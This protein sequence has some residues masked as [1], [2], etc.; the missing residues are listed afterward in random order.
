M[1]EGGR[2]VR[3]VVNREIRRATRGRQRGVELGDADRIGVV[4]AGGDMRQAA[5]EI[6]GI[7][8]APGLC[9]PGGVAKRDNMVLTCYRTAAHGNQN[10]RPS[11]RKSVC[12]NTKYST[13]A[14]A[15]KQK[16]THIK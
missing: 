4:D 16:T 5:A 14:V 10:G 6:G 7:G 3:D 11:C 8:S 9:A 1:G 12:H 15:L 2:G 13:I